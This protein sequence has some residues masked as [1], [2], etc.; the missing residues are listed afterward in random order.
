MPCLCSL[1]CLPRGFN[2][3][4]DFGVGGH[5]PTAASPS[6]ACESAFRYLFSSVSFWNLFLSGMTHR[7]WTRGTCLYMTK[8][9]KQNIT[10]WYNGII[11]VTVSR[12]LVWVEQIPRAKIHQDY[13]IVLDPYIREAAIDL[14]LQGIVG[15]NAIVAMYWRGVMRILS[16]FASRKKATQ[17][18][19]LSFCMD[20]IVW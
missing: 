12:H 1:D 11:F 18:E 3:G 5:V 6:Q 14:L 7:G 16:L 2:L 20:I 10:E 13:E 17:S 8:C 9:E 15:K 19:V 4:D